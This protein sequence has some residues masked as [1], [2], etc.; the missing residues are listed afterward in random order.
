MRKEH[1][2][3]LFALVKKMD[4][5]EDLARKYPMLSDLILKNKITCIEE[6]KSI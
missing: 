3:E 5:A 6:L 2:E 4:K 1:R